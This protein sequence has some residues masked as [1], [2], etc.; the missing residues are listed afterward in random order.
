MSSTCFTGDVTSTWARGTGSSD[1]KPQEIGVEDLIDD[2]NPPFDTGD[3]FDDE[4][5]AGQR[6]RL[7]ETADID[8]ARERNAERFGAVDR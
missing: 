8:F 2:A 5:V 3:T 7:I 4:I 6:S 1:L